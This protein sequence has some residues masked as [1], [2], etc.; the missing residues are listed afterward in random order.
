MCVTEIGLLTVSNLG[1]QFNQGN[2]AGNVGGQFPIGMP[3]ILQQ[4][5][6]QAQ[7]VMGGQEMSK[8]A[9]TYESGQQSLITLPL[10][11]TFVVQNRPPG[12]LLSG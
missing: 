11:M 1:F 10:K 2:V 12:K 8:F 7:P 6:Q 4:Q 5:Q 9:I 3:N